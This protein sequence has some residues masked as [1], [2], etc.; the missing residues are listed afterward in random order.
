MPGTEKLVV[1]MELSM[2]FELDIFSRAGDVGLDADYVEWL[3]D[4]HSVNVARHFG[5]FWE[6]YA[7]SMVEASGQ[8]ACERKVSES[9]RCYVQ[10]Q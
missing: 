2:G 3:V 10:A 7:N 8:G 4:E 6:Y 9:G 1:E 5:K